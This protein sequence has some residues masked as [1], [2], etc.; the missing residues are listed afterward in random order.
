MHLMGGWVTYGCKFSILFFHPKLWFGT[1]K[2]PLF[3]LELFCHINSKISN[4]QKSEAKQRPIN[5]H[6]LEKDQILNNQ[7]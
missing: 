5:D 3:S 2:F 4:N 6:K 1:F 7:D